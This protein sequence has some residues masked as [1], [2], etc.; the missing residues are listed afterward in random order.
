MTC[1]VHD[2][3]CHRLCRHWDEAF[4]HI[5]R[6]KRARVRRVETPAE[7]I[8]DASPAPCRIHRHRRHP[9]ICRFCRADTR[10]NAPPVAP[11]E[12]QALE[13]AEG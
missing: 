9:R 10:T 8:S 11:S 13:R 7:L 5:R 4:A 1:P 12:D 2:Y 3:H 6:F